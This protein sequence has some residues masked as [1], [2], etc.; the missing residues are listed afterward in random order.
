MSRFKDLLIDCFEG[1]AESALLA[2]VEVYRVKNPTWEAVE[3]NHMV[4][5][6]RFLLRRYNKNIRPGK[7]NM[8]PKTTTWTE[9]NRCFLEQIA[10]G[11][12]RALDVFPAARKNNP[13]A[14]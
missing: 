10:L 13:L 11:N 4:R 9:F 5:E 6:R 12:S 1:D 14:N 7:E 3:H 8:L 2:A